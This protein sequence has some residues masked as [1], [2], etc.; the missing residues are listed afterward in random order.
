[1][2]FKIM[3]K[4]I[5]VG[6]KWFI[7]CTMAVSFKLQMK[8]FKSVVPVIIHTRSDCYSGKAKHNFCITAVRQDF[9]NQADKEI[10]SVHCHLSPTVDNREQ[11]HCT[12]YDSY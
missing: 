1:M 3:I 2:L 6:T 4:K 9:F 5:V 8:C 7:Q 12:T 11:C 10:L